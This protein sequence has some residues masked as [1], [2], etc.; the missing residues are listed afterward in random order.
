M[1]R[2]MRAPTRSVTVGMKFLDA[3]LALQEE[4][5]AI[6]SDRDLTRE[7]RARQFDKEISRLRNKGTN[8]QFKSYPAYLSTNKRNA[9]IIQRISWKNLPFPMV[10][11][12]VN[13]VSLPSSR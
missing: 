6:Y 1:T 8:R 11:V 5:K 12:F 10:Y 4:L 7:K 13:T 3:S 2:F 9:E